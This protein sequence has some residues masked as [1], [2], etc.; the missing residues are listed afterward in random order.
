MPLKA[1]A[2]N[3]ALKSL[4]SSEASSTG[5]LLELITEE[6]KQYGVETETIRLADATAFRQVTPMRTRPQDPRTSVY[7]QPAIRTCAARIADLTGQKSCNPR[8]LRLVQLI[9]FDCH[10]TPHVRTW[11]PM[12]HRLRRSGI[13]MSI[14]PSHGTSRCAHRFQSPL[15]TSGDRNEV[16]NRP[17]H[18]SRIRD[19]KSRGTGISE[20]WLCNWCAWTYGG[21]DL[22]HG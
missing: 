13:L 1:R 17:C 19:R 20:R 10:N 21:R 22:L 18:W 2:L 16:S 9:S 6:F 15:E 14:R 3:G 11:S 7:E 12:N 4:D 8:P 5:R